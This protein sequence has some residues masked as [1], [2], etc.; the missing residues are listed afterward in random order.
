MEGRLWDLRADRLAFST[1]ET[2][3]L[4][5]RAGL[6]LSPGQADRLQRRTGGWVAGLRLAVQAMYSA[7]DPEAFLA[8]FS[9]D[10]RSVA[11]YLVGEVLDTLPAP[12]RE[13]LTVASITDPL[14]GGLAVEITGREDAVEVLERLERETSLLE[15]LAGDQHEYR[16]LELLRTYLDADSPSP[17]R[18][19]RRAARPCRAVVGR[20]GRARG[21]PGACRTGGR[22][23]PARGAA[24]PL[25]AVARP[26]REPRSAA[27][28]P[29]LH[30]GGRPPP[31]GGAPT[32]G[33]TALGAA[34]VRDAE[35]LRA[36]RTAVADVLTAGSPDAPVL[37]ELEALDR[38]LGALLATDPDGARDGLE[39]ALAIAGRHG[40]DFA[41]VQCR[42]LLAYVAAV[43]GD[44]VARAD[45]QR[46]STGGRR[47]PAGS[48]ATVG[49]V[50]VGDARPRPA[51]VRRLQQADPESARSSTEAALSRPDAT[52]P[53][54][55]RY[56]LRVVG[57]AARADAG[58]PG[59]GLAEIRSA[60]VE[61]DGHTLP[62]RLEAV[63]A[64]LEHRAALRLG[65][66]AG[67][68]DGASG[69]TGRDDAS[70]EV[71]LLA[72]WTDL[73][74]DRAGAASTRVA[75]IVA[76]THV[77]LLPHVVVEAQVV[78]AT[79][80]LR[81][82][83]VAAARRC[84]RA[85]L[86]TAGPLDLVRPFVQAGEEVGEL[87]A[88]RQQGDEPFA[89]RVRAAHRTAGG[90]AANARLTDR[91]PPCSSCSRP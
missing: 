63:A 89:A 72:A 31:P 84:L 65:H 90:P 40:F 48:P 25:R 12:T 23:R 13:F 6:P 55:L 7:D 4:V 69:L 16:I 36:L 5:R 64:L 17:S 49:A 85:A 66:P 77:P 67:A 14:P 52:V 73:D 15:E 21:R 46:G 59:D 18:P 20:P 42:T 87:L 57:G 32:S 10:D 78:Q 38:G 30:A 60:R 50:G 3:V 45:A 11:D 9:G 33:A 35:D 91:E 2:A 81:A 80:D 43:R 22:P 41:A 37:A 56:A 79:V 51:R 29:G 75:G 47:R 1:A 61:L 62:A 82:G 8:D 58:E 88:E 39:E 44:H 19:R 83:D 86:A 26:D 54:T 68:T 76:G 74:R 28:G 70:A 71:A 24:G 34:L 53:P 27:A